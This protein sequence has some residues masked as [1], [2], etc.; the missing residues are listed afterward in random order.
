MPVAVPTAIS[1][2]SG[3]ATILV[4]EM[5]LFMALLKDEVVENDEV[6]YDLLQIQNDQVLIVYR[7]IDKAFFEVEV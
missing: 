3:R 1:M 2:K 4:L 6:E 7:L 5:L